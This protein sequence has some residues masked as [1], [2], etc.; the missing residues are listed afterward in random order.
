MHNGPY[1]QLSC[2]YEYAVLLHRTLV[3]RELSKYHPLLQFAEEGKLWTTR[4]VVEFFMS[5]KRA[6][7]SS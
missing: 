7:P 3:P 1:R 4:N 6:P 5:L 2:K